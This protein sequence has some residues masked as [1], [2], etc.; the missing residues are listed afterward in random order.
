METRNNCY[1][2]VTETRFCALVDSWIAKCPVLCHL[3]R[4]FDPRFKE[5]IHRHPAF[6]IR[7]INICRESYSKG[8]LKSRKSHQQPSCRRKPKWLLVSNKVTLKQIKL[9]FVPLVIQLVWY[10]LKQ[11]FTSTSVNNC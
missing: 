9:L 8:R 1:I 3:F 7:D 2:R 4:C 6:V 11:L 10:I 5:N